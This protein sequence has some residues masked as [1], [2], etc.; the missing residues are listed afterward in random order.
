MPPATATSVAS[1]R[2]PAIAGTFYPADPGALAADIDRAVAAAP[3]LGGAPKALVAPHAGYVYSGP[4]AASA[5]AQVRPQ[6]TAIRRVALLGPCHRVPVRGLAVPS[7]AAFRTPLGDVP[8]DADAVAELGGLPFVEVSD[9]A[10]AQEH[11]LETHLPFL[12]RVLDDF[13]IVPVVVGA[14]SPVQVE[15]ALSK[16]WGGSETLIVISSDLSHYLSYDAAQKRD[17]AAALAIET[18]NGAGLADD[19]ACGR[20]A[21][22]GLL[23][24]ARQLDLRPTTL[25]LRNSGDTAG[26]KKRV[27]GYGA[28]MLE[29]AA[30]A[31]LPETQRAALVQ[32]AR[33]TILNSIGQSA[34]Q[35]RIEGVNRPLATARATFVTIKLDG[36]LRGCVGSVSPSR[37]IVV[38]VAE[39][40]YKAAFG[41]PRFPPV[42]RAEA[43]RLD[44]HISVLST[45]RPIEAASDS[46]LIRALA[47]DRDGLVLS[48]GRRRG[49][50]LPSVWE[51]LPDTRNFVGRLKEK[52]GLSRDY[53][54]ADVKAY[55]FSTES[56]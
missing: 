25:D 21:L 4:V 52:A 37:P 28:W 50:F 43:E 51:S 20:H 46:E 55:R 54:G 7:V 34:P 14:A 48:A 6:K 38:D 49:L 45:L 32:I 56:F 8:V 13:S 15:Q 24:R 44:I 53:W 41:D 16:I 33:Q 17:G 31:R 19:Q 2:P 3:V 39:N 9:A 27:V 23:R 11:S 40:A 5:Y 35:I 47:P 12:Q 42:S 1:F 30:T 29:Y 36:T 10:H 18:L 22:R 26:D